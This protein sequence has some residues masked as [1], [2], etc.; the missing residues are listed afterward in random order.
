MLAVN[1]FV[2]MKEA[3]ATPVWTMLAGNTRDVDV[4]KVEFRPGIVTGDRLICERADFKESTE[5]E[6]VVPEIDVSALFPSIK[7]SSRAR[8]GSMV[9][10]GET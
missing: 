6:S 2:S 4:I 9:P 3:N 7:P 8:Q 10:W 1:G 5:V